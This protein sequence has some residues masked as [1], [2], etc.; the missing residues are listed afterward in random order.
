MTS[1]AKFGPRGQVFIEKARLT[2][3]PTWKSVGFFG[4]KVLVVFSK[5]YGNLD[6]KR[7]PDMVNVY[8]T[9]ERSTKLIMG[10]LT[11]SIWRFCIPMLNYQRVVFGMYLAY[12]WNFV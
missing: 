8:I 5:T 4:V 12:I 7:L 1:R 11:I 3:A 10:K 6:G 2:K 9:M